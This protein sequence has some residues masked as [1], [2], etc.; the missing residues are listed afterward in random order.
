M[1][2]IL[3]LAA[4]LA[5]LGMASQAAEAR[6]RTF[7][8]R[9]FSPHATP[10]LH[11]LQRGFKFHHRGFFG[12]PRHF[13]PRHFGHFN[14]RG[15][16]FKFGDHGGFVFKFGHIPHFKP[17]PFGLGHRG[18]FFEFGHRHFEPRHRRGFAFGKPWHFR[19]GHLMGFDDSSWG[20]QQSPRGA[21][22]DT[23]SFEVVLKQLEEQGF[24][25]VPRL[26]RERSY[27]QP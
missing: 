9:H 7:S 16:V 22:S 6:D 23:A 17:H 1:R 8:F 13:K 15:L 26:L 11:V 2:K 18:P 10:R 27:W 24:R 25:H 20:S 4:I 12:E 21:V 14:H 5:A 3:A 19:S